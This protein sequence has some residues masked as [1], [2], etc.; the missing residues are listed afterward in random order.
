MIHRGN[1]GGVSGG[2]AAVKL[3]E[4]VLVGDKIV[5]YK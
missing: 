4:K 3:P 2:I 5:C 1:T